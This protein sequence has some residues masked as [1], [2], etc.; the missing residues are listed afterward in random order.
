MDNP[1]KVQCFRWNVHPANLFSLSFSMPKH[2]NQSA[3]ICLFKS[4]FVLITT[5]ISDSDDLFFLKL[6]KHKLPCIEKLYCV[7]M[8]TV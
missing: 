3:K 5:I 1:D 7:K 2:V 8:T 6:K 4:C